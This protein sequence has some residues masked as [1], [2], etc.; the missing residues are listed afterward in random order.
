MPN[1][2]DRAIEKRP[3]IPGMN[4]LITGGTRGIGAATAVMLAEAGANVVVTYRDSGK[5]RR[6]K[7]FLETAL[8]EIKPP[9]QMLYK[10]R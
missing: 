2:P 8:S 9:G 10:P 7:T 4:V 6:V 5:E 3:S 1:S